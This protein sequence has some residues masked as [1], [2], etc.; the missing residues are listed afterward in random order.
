MTAPTPTPPAR[1]AVAGAELTRAAPVSTSP[2]RPTFADVYA[3]QYRRTVGLAA[4]LVD[5]LET[6]EEITQDAFV[7][8]HR[9]WIHVADPIPYL[10]RSVVNGGRDV[11]RRR[12]VRRRTEERDL[13]G[14]DAALDVNHLDDV[15]RRLPDRQ[16]AAI[17]LRYCEGLGDADIAEALGVRQPTVRT[18]VRRGLAQLRTQVER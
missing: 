15:V 6:A 12:A 1:T 14:E 10:R 8:L 7:A 16:R 11:Q 4:L 5:D 2:A 13:L 17:V 18:L 9:N 3:D